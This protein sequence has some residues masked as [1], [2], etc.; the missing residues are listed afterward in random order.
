MPG[1]PG[2]A[3]TISTDALKHLAALLDRFE[4]V[5]N[6]L[7]TDAQAAEQEFFS[8]VERLFKDFVL[9]QGFHLSLVEFRGH[10]VWRCKQL[11]AAERRKPPILPSL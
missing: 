8:E 6:P 5:E 7:S 3:R 9:G 10:L 4:N 11:L 2:A 1:E